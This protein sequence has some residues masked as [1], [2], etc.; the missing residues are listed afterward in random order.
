MFQS[1]QSSLPEGT[2]TKDLGRTLREKIPNNTRAG[3]C[4]EINYN[5]RIGF[6]R[7]ISITTQGLVSAERQ[8]SIT[9]QGLVSA[10]REKSITTQGLVSA[11]RFQ[12][13]HKDWFLQRVFNYNTAS[14][15]P[16]CF[17][18]PLS[19]KGFSQWDENENR[20]HKIF[21]L[22]LK[23]TKESEIK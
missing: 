20:N 4:R 1:T 11:E 22:A 10:E 6:C 15:H 7:E 17:L 12:L 9:T 8:K 13:Q 18:C 21:A 16:L 14:R 3:C 23:K 19:I 5:M 2:I